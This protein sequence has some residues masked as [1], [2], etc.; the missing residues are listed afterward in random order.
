MTATRPNRTGKATGND[1]VMTRPLSAKFIMQ[2]FRPQG[3]IMDPCRGDGA[4]HRLMP[5]GSDWCEISEGRDFLK[6]SGSAD[7]IVTNP[8][9]SI[10]DIFLT[11]ATEVA[12]NIVFLCPP[13]KSF[14]SEKME[15]VIQ[16]FG[17]IREVVNMGHGR[18]HGFPFG[19]VVGCI[20]Y[21]RGY[22]GD[23]KYTRAWELEEESL[24]LKARARVERT[25]IR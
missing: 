12:D 4:F 14:K 16:S 11:K 10:F 6:Y 9:F 19:F 22:R 21:Q 13:Q 7:W 17:G 1:V 3:T 23:I 15:R 20:H 5:S 24:S 18:K 25:P 2:H 8:P